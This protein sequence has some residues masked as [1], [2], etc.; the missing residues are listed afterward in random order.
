[1]IFRAI[2][3]W[4]KHIL[5]L[6]QMVLRCMCN[7]DLA[8]W[9]KRTYLW[10]ISCW[11]WIQRLVW[12]LTAARLQLFQF[13]SS[14]H[15]VAN[16]ILLLIDLHVGQSVRVLRYLYAGQLLLGGLCICILSNGLFIRKYGVFILFAIW[17][18]LVKR[19]RCIKALRT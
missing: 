18:A 5:R 19:I 11:L 2:R 6:C 1:M 15:E 16:L 3:I 8:S 13:D 14:L 4:I 9:W 17:V 12:D 10:F 7:V